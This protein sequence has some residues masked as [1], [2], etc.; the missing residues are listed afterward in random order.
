M[1]DI[2]D[3]LKKLPD[4]PGVYIMK[5]E[6]SEI[7]YIGK[8]VVLKNRV[9]QYF[10][11][12]ANHSP[13]TRMMISRIREFEYI[14]TDTELEA[15]I[16]ECNLI[17]K[18]KPRFNI[19]LKDDKN[20]YPYIKI[21]MNEEYPRVLMTRKI[22]KDGAR[23]F[24]PF[25]SA[26]AVRE[27]L[28][29][30]NK[31]FPIK[32]CNKV[33]PRDIGKGRPCL[34][35]YI[36]QCFGPCQGDVK[37]DEYR[38]LMK[39]IASFLDGRQEDILLRL[40]KQMSKASDD[41]EFEKAASIRDKMNRLKQITEK[42]KVLSTSMEDKDV[43]GFSKD[44]TD[45]CVQIFYIRSGKL[46]GRGHFIF[47]GVGDTEGVEL[48]TSFVKQFYSTAAFI[49]NE[50]LIQEG[51]DEKEFLEN[52]LSEK[53]TSKVHIRVPLKGEK[54]KLI[55]MVSENALIALNQFKD[56][57]KKEDMKSKEGLTRLVEL[58]KLTK[59][60]DRIEAYDISNTGITEVVGSMVVFE[61]GSPN[62]KEYRRFK[63]KSVSG[64]NDYESMREVIFR[65]FKHAEKEKADLENAVF[66]EKNLKETKFLKLPDLI[67]LDGGLG[68]VNAVSAILKELSIDIDI[69]GMVKDDKHRTR[70]LVSQNGEYNLSENL[71]LLRFI[72]S[73]QDE[74]HRFALDYNKKLREKRYSGSVLDNIEGI[75]A[76][77]KKTLIKHFGSVNKIKSAG[78]DDLNAV[79]GISNTVAEKIYKHF[80][81]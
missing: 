42:Q 35:Y 31:I 13:K 18:H 39:D 72:T 50:I 23:Y 25:F 70:G 8:A 56:R 69:Y 66:V 17:K 75:G 21:T 28:D 6:N 59:E 14:V 45:S 33:L 1:F 7:I 37:K 40:E 78:V 55:E 20:F 47:E 30:I 36:F 27:T 62:N 3:E 73:I 16:L 80:R 77:R 22:E 11:A 57:A 63:I 4:R 61:K 52:W 71:V 60:P 2:Q 46:I 38:A 43:I 32:S 41:L 26:F 9:R 49:P 24:G 74:A 44:Q 5:D 29:L 10:Q 53:R 51:I 58:L 68:H 81:D 15:L 65:R 19:L 54:L 64:Q 48:M 34:N 76:K 12:S 79:E 67:L